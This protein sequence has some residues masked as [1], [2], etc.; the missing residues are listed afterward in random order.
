MDKRFHLTFSWP[1][2]SV[3]RRALVDVY[4]DLSVGDRVIAADMLRMFRTFEF[5]YDSGMCKVINID[6]E[7]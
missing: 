3:L 4:Y 1:R 5:D 7:R 2:I 6:F